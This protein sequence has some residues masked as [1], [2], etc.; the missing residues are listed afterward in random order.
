M[1]LTQL[2]ASARVDRRETQSAIEEIWAALA[3]AR[4]PE[5]R[6]GAMLSDLIESLRKEEGFRDEE[7]DF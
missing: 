5:H 2:L 7:D 3:E 1:T 4:T 6:A